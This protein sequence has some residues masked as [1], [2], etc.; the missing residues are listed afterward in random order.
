MPLLILTGKSPNDIVKH[1]RRHV[2]YG[3]IEPYDAQK[4]ARSQKRSNIFSNY[5]TSRRPS[6]L[7]GRQ[8]IAFVNR[9]SEWVA[10]DSRPMRV[11]KD[12]V[13]VSIIMG[14]VASLREWIEDLFISV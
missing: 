12:D 10:S 9:C 6:D 2:L 4:R 3:K 7:E 13:F 1:L 5:F 8:Q 11:V 14:L